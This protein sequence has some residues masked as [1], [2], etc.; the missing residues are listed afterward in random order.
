MVQGELVQVKRQL[1]DSAA[2]VNRLTVDLASARSE[3]H[4]L[5][6]QVADLGQKV[7]DGRGCPPRMTVQQTR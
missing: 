5:Q 4:G 6:A 1:S 3:A 7:R 2:Q